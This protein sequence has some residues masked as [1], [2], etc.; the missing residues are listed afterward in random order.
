M[1]LDVAGLFIY[2]SFI[3]GWDVNFQ[4]VRIA[5]IS[6]MLILGKV[7][8]AEA[9]YYVAVNASNKIGEISQDKLENIFS[10]RLIFWESGGRI[11]PSLI[12]E[13]SPSGRAFLTQV[14]KMDSK[15]YIDFWRRK[16]FSGRG[17]PPRSFR[18]EKELIH[19]VSEN[20]GAIAVLSSL[21]GAAESSIRI[22]EV[23][24]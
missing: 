11:R 18:S 13:E 16:L 15:Q 21:P 1:D 24:H 4:A 19:F 17:L 7:A 23:I 20:E 2:E 22:V 3:L 6:G 5:V 8:S 12:D 14:V 9:T 10:G